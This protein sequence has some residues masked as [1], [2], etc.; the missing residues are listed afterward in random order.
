MTYVVLAIAAVVGLAAGLAAGYKAGS[1]LVGRRFWFW[2]SVALLFVVSTAI[3]GAALLGDRLWLA[4]A[5]LGLLTGCLT[6]MKYGWD[7]ELRTLL[8]RSG[9]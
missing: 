8:N 4:V 9:R 6:G 3:V 2:A 5:M 7:T 1:A